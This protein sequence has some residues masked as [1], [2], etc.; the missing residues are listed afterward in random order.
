MQKDFS[1]TYELLA[2]L[3]YFD[4]QFW[5]SLP[6]SLKINMLTCRGK[7]PAIAY[8]FSTRLTPTGNFA[9]SSYLNYFAQGSRF[10]TFSLKPVSIKPFVHRWKLGACPPISGIM[11]GS[12]AGDWCVKKV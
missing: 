11:D 6:K 10:R 12:E 5:S 8:G 1:I 2:K 9:R 3:H 7:A 4:L